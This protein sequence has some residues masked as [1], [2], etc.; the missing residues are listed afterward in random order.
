M[1]KPALSDICIFISRKEPAAFLELLDEELGRLERIER[2][3]LLLID[4]RLQF[5]RVASLENDLKHLLLFLLLL[6]YVLF[7][8]VYI[9]F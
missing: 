3:V 5:N 8:A 9:E 2:A 1:L 7:Q 4:V 6:R